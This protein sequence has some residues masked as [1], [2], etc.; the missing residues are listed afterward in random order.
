MGERNWAGN[1]VYGA[2]RVLRPRT[3]DEV[4][5][6]V[7]GHAVV[8]AVGTRH[9]FS[10]VAD[11]RGTHLDLSDLDIPVEIDAQAR[12]VT[13]GA[14]VRYGDV[15]P[16]LHDAGFALGNLASLPHCSVAG[17]VATATHGSGRANPTLS[18]AVSGVELVTADGD[19]RRF[20][21]ADDALRGAAVGLGALG[22]VTRVTLDLVRPYDL[23]QD[24]YYG[25]GWGALLEAWDEVQGCGYSVSLFTRWV[26]DDPGMIMVKTR[27]E[28]GAEF[29]V[30]AVLAP[31]TAIAE[32]PGPH[33]TDWGTPG[34]WHTRLPHFR[35][36]ATPSVGEEL[37]SE[38][39]V[40]W[41]D[42]VPALTALREIGPKLADALFV[43]EIRAVAGDDLWL[44]PAHG[45]DRLCLHFT[46]QPKPEAVAAL[47]P[48]IE[49]RLA[50]F[51]ARAHWGKLATA[52][53]PFAELYPEL[54]RFRAL[55]ESLDP[56]GKFG[57]DY[58][59]QRVF[60]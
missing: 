22:V 29:A 14:G 13:V 28:P 56:G 60:R 54:P 32:P 47:L 7:A 38:Y 23:R 5:E 52:A 17:T 6:L 2:E 15:A 58:L 41:A 40:P 34:P 36:E 48:E 33:F 57:N 30:P 37:Q 19:L 10:D 53:L 12:T 18:A 21:R 50:P 16:A 8:K 44:S 39:F 9:S 27:V 26:E 51:G 31:A 59:D 20:T 42:A 55:A 4:R 11:S 49:A 43:S 45:G 46:W 35:L 3:V 25:L 1:L 24:A